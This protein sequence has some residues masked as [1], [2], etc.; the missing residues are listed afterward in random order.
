MPLSDCSVCKDGVALCKPQSSRRGE[1]RAEERPPCE[2][3]SADWGSEATLSRDARGRP[4]WS[5]A[6]QVSGQAATH[7]S[8]WLKEGQPARPDTRPPSCECAAP[9]GSPPHVRD[10]GPAQADAWR[11]GFERQ[12]ERA[13][14]RDRRRVAAQQGP[15]PVNTQDRIRRDGWTG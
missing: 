7:H 8:R 5:L 11:S 1:L 3:S 15:A 13:R 4:L 12:A 6:H 14:S 9:G 2:S 10:G